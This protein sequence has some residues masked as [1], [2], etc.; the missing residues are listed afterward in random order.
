[1]FRIKT[2]LLALAIAALTAMPASAAYV[3]VGPSFGSVTVN[4]PSPPGG[5]PGNTTAATGIISSNDFYTWNGIGVDSVPLVSNILSGIVSSQGTSI[6]AVT[7]VSN[8]A[9]NPTLASPP[10]LPVSGTSNMSRRTTGLSYN[11]DFTENESLLF[12]NAANGAL[13]IDFAT[14]VSAAGLRVQADAFGT[15][16]TFFLQAFN[17]NG[18]TFDPSSP[19]FGNLSVTTSSFTPGS[20]SAPFYGIDTTAGETFTR[21]WLGFGS[22]SPFAISTLEI[23]APQQPPVDPVPVPPTV[24]LGIA[25]AIGL[26][27]LRKARRG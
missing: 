14:P 5:A 1:M 21:L 10:P 26:A 12:A 24:F 2:G 27:R 8:S 4:P 23:N 15:D 18:T 20:D 11:A 6:A 3:L 19:L 17:F 13:I 22:G 25:G 7:L 16:N 9:L